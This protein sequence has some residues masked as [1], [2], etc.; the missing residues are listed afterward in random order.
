[1]LLEYQ[2]SII[3]IFLMAF[4]GGSTVTKKPGTIRDNPL[5]SGNLLSDEQNLMVKLRE[6]TN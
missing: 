5:K 3:S 4:K 2:L 1:M 6:V